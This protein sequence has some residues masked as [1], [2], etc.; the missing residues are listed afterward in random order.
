MDNY[1]EQRIILL[2]NENATMPLG[3]SQLGNETFPLK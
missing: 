1:K 3:T 2:N